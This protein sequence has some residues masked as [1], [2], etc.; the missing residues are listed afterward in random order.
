MRSL[1]GLKPLAEIER[2]IALVTIDRCWRDYL[3]EV[4]EMRDDS[5]LLAFAG[6]IPLAEFHRQVGHTFL[7]LEERIEEDTVRTFEAIE[8]SGDGVDWEQAGLRGP[9]ATWTYLIGENPFGAGG[10]L[11]PTHRPV[12]GLA[13]AAFPFLLLLQ[14]LGQLWK[15]RRDRRARAEASSR[16]SAP[17]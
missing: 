6:K 7:A 11:S 12:V 5:H 16:T 17:R 4:R 3:A 1:V 2:R 15:G 8:I 13:A 9:S 14:G 10:I